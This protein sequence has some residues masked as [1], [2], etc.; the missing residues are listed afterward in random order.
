MDL[1]IKFQ[2]VKN[3]EVTLT[4]MTAMNKV[5]SIV[6]WWLSNGEKNGIVSPSK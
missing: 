2:T 3:N 5:A 4:S 1:S 6:F